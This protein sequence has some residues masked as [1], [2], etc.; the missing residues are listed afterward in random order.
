LIDRPADQKLQQITLST[1]L[2]MIAL[3]VI[4]GCARSADERSYHGAQHCCHGFD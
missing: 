3:L 4:A 1:S 2:T